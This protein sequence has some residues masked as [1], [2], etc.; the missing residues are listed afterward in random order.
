MT[1]MPDRP[2]N[3]RC[4]GFDVKPGVSYHAHDLPRCKRNGTHWKDGIVGGRWTC[5]DHDNDLAF[6]GADRLRQELAVMGVSSAGMINGAVPKMTIPGVGA[7]APVPIKNV[8]DFVEAFGPTTTIPGLG[9]VRTVPRREVNHTHRF[10]IEIDGYGHPDKTLP[11]VARMLALH[12]HR[13]LGSGEDGK[14]AVWRL[15]TEDGRLVMFDHLADDGHHAGH[16]I[17]L[18]LV[19]APH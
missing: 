6:P 1:T 9:T 3:L 14:P 17:P 12:L 13:A 5:D 19:K 15:V 18:L 4:E 10:V 11:E 7:V 2:D 8:G 16:S